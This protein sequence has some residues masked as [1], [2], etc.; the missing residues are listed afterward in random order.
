MSEKFCETHKRA[1]AKDGESSYEFINKEDYQEAA[2]VIGAEIAE[3]LAE[4]QYHEHKDFSSYRVLR[5]FDNL[6]LLRDVEFETIRQY[7]ALVGTKYLRNIAAG[8]IYYNEIMDQ[9]GILYVLNF[10]NEVD[11]NPQVKGPNRNFD[12]QD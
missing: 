2:Q 6:W 11:P 12:V 10:D 5:E 1:K 8:G 3:E 4:L 7:S 9:P